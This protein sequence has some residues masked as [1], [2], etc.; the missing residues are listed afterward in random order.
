VCQNNNNHFKAL[1]TLSGTT[2]VSWYQKKHSPTHTYHGYQSSLI[3]FLHLLLSTSWNLASLSFTLNAPFL[4]RCAL[5]PV[6][7]YRAARSI[8][9]LYTRTAR[10]AMDRQRLVGCASVPAI[11][12]SRWSYYD[13]AVV[14]RQQTCGRSFYKVLIFFP[15]MTP[16]DMRPSI[17]LAHD[18]MRPHANF[19]HS[20]LSRFGG[21]R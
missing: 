15:T 4:S 8:W 13:V 12:T 11:M 18:G 16:I 6:N 1:W 10:C 2:R 17:D 14:P 19:C 20:P 21:D 5:H 3:C 7:I 9:A